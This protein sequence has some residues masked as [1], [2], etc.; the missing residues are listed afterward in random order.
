MMNKSYAVLRIRYVYPDEIQLFTIPDPNFSIPVR[1]SKKGQNGTGS[2]SETL[3]DTAGQHSTIPA[4]LRHFGPTMYVVIHS[5]V[6]SVPCTTNK[7]VLSCCEHWLDYR[8]RDGK[9]TDPWFGINIQEPQNNYKYK[10]FFRRESVIIA[11]YRSVT[12]STLTVFY[13]KFE[14]KSPIPWYKLHEMTS[15]LLDPDPDP[16]TQ[17]NPDPM[18]SILDP[19]NLI[20]KRG[21][22]TIQY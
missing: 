12:G 16:L 4:G 1:G 2:G 19:Q 21:S 11:E 3:T 8:I 18:L 15:T 6:S 5:L 17:L 22:T 7:K 13:N 14:K 20:K 10:L 9:M